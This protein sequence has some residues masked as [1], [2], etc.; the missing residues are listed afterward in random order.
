MGAMMVLDHERCYRAV[1]SRDRRFDG[2]FVGA[3]STTGIYCR[4]S[5][6]AVAPKR[7]NIAFYPT[8]ATAQQHGYRACKRCRPDASPGSPEWNG[9]GD[10]V[11]R[12]MRLVADGVVEREGVS[13][14]ARRLA[15]SPRHLNRLVTD[16]LGAG[17]LAIARAQR[18]ETAR[19]LIETTD[20]DF[21]TIAHAAGFGSV[22][23]FNDT[24]RAVFAD[25]PTALRA[26]ASNGGRSG[27]ETGAVDLELPVRE[28]FGATALLGFLASRAIPRIEHWDG[29]TYHRSLALPHGHGVAEVA[30]AT[31]RSRPVVTARLRL[32]DWRDLG[33]AVR[34]L[35]RLLDLDAD[36]IAVDAVLGEDPALAPA[37]AAAPGRRSPGA[38][39]PFEIAVR[40]VVGQQISVAGA[41]TVIGRI[42]DAVGE[43]LRIVARP[44]LTHVFPTAAA[45]AEI[46]PEHLPMPASRRRTITELAGRVADGRIVLDGGADRD[47]LSAALDAVPGIGPWTIGYVQMRGLGDPD[48]FLP[49]DLGVR[50][51]LAQLGVGAVRA[52]EWRPWRSYALHHLWALP[53]TPVPSPTGSKRAKHVTGAK[54]RFGTAGAPAPSPAASSEET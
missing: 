28:P 24:V 8:A 30:A 26:A 6:P 27:A 53:T 31:R 29:E 12:A 17:P 52:E 1:L 41:R 3:V 13:G 25:T 22:R 15:Y 23:Q 37:V 7:G 9:R 42:V 19:T 54:T 33:P 44:E 5:C 4:P 40:A 38:V 16:E 34:R 35:R 20:L 2:W 36:P 46:D 14:L 48:V 10:V 11:A 51:G 18:A 21:T 43:P 49:T 45:L 39:D 50:A 32:E 47:E